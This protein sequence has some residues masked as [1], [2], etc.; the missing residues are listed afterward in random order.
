MQTPKD[1]R[2]RFGL[3]PALV[4]S[5]A[6]L[7]LLAVGAVGA[8]SY[9]A[10]RSI[11]REFGSVTI[12]ENLDRLESELRDEM[13]AVVHQAQFVS[14]AIIGGTY[15]FAEPQRLADFASGSMAAAPQIGGILLAGANS[16]AIRVMRTI[17][18]DTVTTTFDL[19][20]R[21]NLQQLA[22]LARNARGSFWIEPVYSTT[23]RASLLGLCVPI[24]YEDRYLGFIVVS[25]LT[26]TLSAFADELSDPPHVTAFMLY[27][28]DFVLAHPSLID[29][30]AKLSKSSPLLGFDKVGDVVLANLSEGLPFHEVGISLPEDSEALIVSKNDKHYQVY[31]RAVDGYG[32]KP[33]VIG[34]YYSESIL[35]RVFQIL[36]D[37]VI[38]GIALLIGA[39][40]LAFVLG[41]IIARP[42]ARAARGALA[43]QSFDFDHV[44]TLRHS[45]IIEVDDLARS[46]NR[47]YDGLKSFARYVPR[48][49]VARLI[50]EGLP[51]AG[52]EERALSVMFT[53]IAG[54]SALCEEMSASE[55]AD[56][57]NA[58]LSLVSRCIDGEG[59]TIDKYIGDAAMAFWGAPDTLDNTALPACRAAVAIRAAIVADNRERLARGLAPVRIRIGVHTGP[60]VVGDIGAPERINYTV[61]GDVVNG[62]QRL[63][64]LGKEIDPEAEAIVL[65]SGATAELLP[66]EIAVT[67]EGTFRVKGK[68]HS[69]NV[70]RVG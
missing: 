37:Q 33:I 63:E 27:G 42:I 66:P 20:T 39:I 6:G 30:S 31:M 18:N 50:K 59:G 12:V 22:E 19:E 21:T 57:I 62:A 41:R 28:G 51:G 3:Q 56:F 70:F 46:L 49:L 4:V 9:L 7:V 29:N 25:I 68:E 48:K 2:L 65:I 52:S 36:R 23:R 64:S 11:V 60:L 61:V 15:S 38:V 17:G 69:L 47:A 45:R 54:F 35:N 34:I 32:E 14:Q 10:S 8:V 1:E 16:S 24:R 58:H 26:K 53:D 5:I 44:P 40:I 55:V 43:V 13:D 67:S